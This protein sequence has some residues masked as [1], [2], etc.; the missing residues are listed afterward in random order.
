MNAA[1]IFEFLD[2]STT[3]S[4]AWSSVIGFFVFFFVVTFFSIFSY[5]IFC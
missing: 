3:R 1:L 4:M 2:R 5:I